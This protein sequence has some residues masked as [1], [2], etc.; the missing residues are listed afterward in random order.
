[1]KHEAATGV[2]ER[3]PRAKGHVDEWVNAC[4]GQGTSFSNFDKGGLI[5]EI[6]LI[7]ALAFRA[8]QNIAWDSKTLSVPG[9][10]ELN[11]IINKTYR[12]PW[13]T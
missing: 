3:L 9:K 1:M 13:G 6:G 11:A 12:S 7:G 2:P 10:P 8:G 5:T 4:R